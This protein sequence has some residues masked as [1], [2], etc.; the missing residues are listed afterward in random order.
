M[1]NVVKY[2][3]VLF[4]DV[5]VGS[6]VKVGDYYGQVAVG[7]VEEKRETIDNKSVIVRFGFEEKNTQSVII[8]EKTLTKGQ[9]MYELLE[10]VRS[11]V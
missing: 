5:Q 9:P 8:E 10:I 4:A 11:Y 6:I 3:N 1:D 2:G 7:V